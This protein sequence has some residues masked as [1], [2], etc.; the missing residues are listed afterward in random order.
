MYDIDS[1]RFPTF[2]CD[3]DFALDRAKQVHDDEQLCLSRT[4]RQNITDYMRNSRGE[5]KRIYKKLDAESLGSIKIATC[6]YVSVKLLEKNIMTYLYF[7]VVV[8]TSYVRQ[9][10]PTFVE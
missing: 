2:V 4:S 9:A 1:T 10:I 7:S 5:M 6:K 3:D 8:L